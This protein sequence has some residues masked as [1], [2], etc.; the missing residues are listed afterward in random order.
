[1]TEQV[2]ID[3]VTSGMY[4]ILLSALP[5]LAMGLAVGLIVAVFQTVTSIQE[6][7][8]AFV[9]KIIAVL[10][11][12]VIF[13]PFILENITSFFRQMVENL[14]NFVVPM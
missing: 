8:L 9:P 12:I 14:P 2:V 7:T 6:Q 13:G 3:A 10:V 1:M 5:P 11:S 4:T